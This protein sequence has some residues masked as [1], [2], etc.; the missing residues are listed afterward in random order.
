[1]KK[2][3]LTAVLGICLSLAL[4]FGQDGPQ[5]IS[6]NVIQAK[7][8]LKVAPVYP[9]EAKQ[10]GIQGTVRLE[11]TIEKDGHVADL[12]VVS[13]PAELVLSATDA[14][15]QWLYKPTLLNGEPVAVLTTVDV[16]Y[17]LSQ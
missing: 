4:V 9:V 3:T 12:K 11:V 7:L 15:K 13:G 8:L 1:M 2:I 10:N 16:N 14:V 5:R 17:T 6:G